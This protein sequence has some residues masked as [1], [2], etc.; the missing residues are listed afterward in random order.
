[1][2][3]E[4]ISIE[5]ILFQETMAIRKMILITGQITRDL[6]EEVVEDTG[7]IGGITEDIFK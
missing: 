6:E 1:M 3:K 7:K 5:I 4:T 2:T